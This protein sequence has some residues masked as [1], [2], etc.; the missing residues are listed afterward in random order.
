MRRFVK[1]VYD[2]ILSQPPNGLRYHVTDLYVVELKK[3]KA[4]RIRPSWQR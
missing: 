2:P 3:M 1:I 4:V